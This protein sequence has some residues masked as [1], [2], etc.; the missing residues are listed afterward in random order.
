MLKSIN[1]ALFVFVVG[2][3]LL[4]GA[5][6]QSSD[7]SE[8]EKEETTTVTEQDEYYGLEKVSTDQERNWSEK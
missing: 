8:E 7:T 6:T 3:I 4:L 2:S 5:H 1:V